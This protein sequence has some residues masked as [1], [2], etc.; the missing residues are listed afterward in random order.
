LSVENE[1]N[2]DA[3]ISINDLNTV[4]HRNTLQINTNPENSDELP[5]MEEGWGTVSN[6]TYNLRP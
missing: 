5:E 1:S 6:N 3:Y 2:D 4:E